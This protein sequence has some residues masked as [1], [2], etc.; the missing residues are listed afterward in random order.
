MN[1]ARHANAS[2]VRLSLRRAKNA[3]H[4]TVEDNGTGI[5][6]W[7]DANRPG[8]HGLTIMRER[9]EAFGGDLRVSSIPGKGTRIE[10][11]IPVESDDSPQA[12]KEMH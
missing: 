6:S 11:S 4:M 10:V 12:Q 5:E 7:Q 1:V 9:A 2:Q 8:S 3:V